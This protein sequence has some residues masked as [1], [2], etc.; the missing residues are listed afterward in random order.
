MALGHAA[1]SLADHARGAAAASRQEKRS[2]AMQRARALLAEAE[3]ILPKKSSQQR[4]L[5]RIRQKLEAF[6]AG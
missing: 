3:E 1:G 6:A 2:V 5:N 4:A